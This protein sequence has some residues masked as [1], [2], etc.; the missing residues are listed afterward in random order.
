MWD[1]LAD[2][3]KNLP[4]LLGSTDDAATEALQ[5]I[6]VRVVPRA[7]VIGRQTAKGRF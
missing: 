7:P 2:V 1:P 4:P 6:E 3:E 5:W